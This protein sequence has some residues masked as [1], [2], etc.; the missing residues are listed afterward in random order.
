MTE[1]N[2]DISD[3]VSILESQH[4][5]REQMLVS[6]RK[7]IQLASK[8]IRCTHRG[9]FDLAQEL[10]IQGRQLLDGCE[11]S[12]QEFPGIAAN[13]IFY[14]A[15][16][17][18]V[19]ACV[20]VA[21]IKRADVP[22]RQVLNVEPAAYINGI[23]EAASELRRSVLDLLRNDEIDRASDLLEVMDSVYTMA[24]SIDFPDAL[25]HG[26]RRTTD[27]YRA[28]LERTRGDVTT[29]TIFLRARP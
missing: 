2:F 23:I 18:Y 8:S 21:L 7:V 5:A 11:T 28:V 25:T 13:S 20:T 24:V 12:M 9:E 17:E 15:Q 29:A 22:T 10:N 19:E 14:D 6:S 26:L 3:S 27:A 1:I 16:K 4:N